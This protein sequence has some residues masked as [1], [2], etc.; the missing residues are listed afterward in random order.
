VSPNNVVISRSVAKKYFGDEDPIGKVLQFKD[1]N[2]AATVTGMFDEIPT[3]SHFHFGV[4]A[5]CR[6]SP[7]PGKLPGSPPIISYLVLPEHY[8]YKKLEA[9]LPQEIDKYVAPQLEKA[10]G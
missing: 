3:N 6:P 9:K 5:P 7:R 4:L 2:A 1:N 10:L 8:D